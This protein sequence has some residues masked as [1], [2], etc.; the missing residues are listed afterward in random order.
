MA[1]EAKIFI[2]DHEYQAKYKVC[3]VDRESQEKSIQLIYPGK[4][5]QHEYEANVKV[6]FVEHEYQA[7]I[8]ITRNK[9]PK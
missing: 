2:V 9:F 4:L 6:F 8:L 1:S 5:V 7:N 3:F